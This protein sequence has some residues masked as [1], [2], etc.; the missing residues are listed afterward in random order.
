[1]Q[2]IEL[3]AGCG[4]LSLGLKSV[5]FNLTMANELSPMAAESYAFNFLKED[6]SAMAE[7]SIVPQKTLWLSSSY[8]D[9]QLGSRLRENPYQFPDLDD[10]FSDIKLNGSNLD[11]ALVVGSIITLNKWLSKH[12]SALS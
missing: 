6:L 12:K 5:G 9:I 2:F 4:G 1:M 11:G 10:S 8:P 3:F 7:S